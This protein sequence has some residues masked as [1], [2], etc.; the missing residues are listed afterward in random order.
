MPAE[1]AV[2]TTADVIAAAVVADKPADKR[3][4]E[5][6]GAKYTT[7]AATAMMAIAFTTLPIASSVEYYD[8]T[9]DQ[10]GSRWLHFGFW[11]WQHRQGLTLA[12]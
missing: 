12:N 2:A 11:L 4:A 5:I 7:A 8:D 1:I 6:C 9:G 3:A 10:R